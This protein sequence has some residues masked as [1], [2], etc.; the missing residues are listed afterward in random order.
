MF[1]HMSRLIVNALCLLL[2]LGSNISLAHAQSSYETCQEFLQKAEEELKNR[3]QVQ[4][5]IIEEQ[6]KIGRLPVTRDEKAEKNVTGARELL[7]DTLKTKALGFEIQ[8]LEW[9]VGFLKNSTCWEYPELIKDFD[10][11]FREYLG[12][13]A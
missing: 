5:E 9:H 1:P 2:F 10:T 4:L 8:A 7:I 13:E 11:L 3:E 6:E 12:E